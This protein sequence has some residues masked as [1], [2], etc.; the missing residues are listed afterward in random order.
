MEQASH[1]TNDPEQDSAPACNL[2]GF[3]RLAGSSTLSNE[4]R[5]D[6]S[7]EAMGLREVLKGRVLIITA[8]DRPE[9][10]ERLKQAFGDDPEVE[11]I[12]DRRQGDRRQDNPG[13]P[14]ERRRADRRRQK[15]DDDLRELGV[16]LARPSSHLMFGG[17][18]RQGTVNRPQ[19]SS[20][21]RILIIDD[22]P[23]IVQLLSAF[24]E[25]DQ[26]GYAVAI[27]LDG[28]SALD[29]F[30]SER[31]DVVLLDIRMPGIN[32][33]EVL[34]R[35]R[36]IDQSIPVIMVTAATYAEAREALK[37]GAFAY[38]PKPFDFR[39]I[40]DLVAAAVVNRRPSMQG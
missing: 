18:D 26:R 33:L 35:M 1:P 38:I 9:P 24:F 29:N 27:A 6:F 2:V 22:D 5:A 13:R 28:E 32:G 36:N 21:C 15:I 23:R 34:K 3:L 31:P 25:S 19:G 4:Q 12:V 20:D 17:R 7:R 39:Y 8:K 10:Y 14:L 37:H 11:V 16:A 30:R 40:D